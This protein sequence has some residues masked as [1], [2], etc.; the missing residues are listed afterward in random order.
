MTVYIMHISLRAQCVC[1]RERVCVCVHF[2]CCF[3]DARSGAS[4]SSAVCVVMESL[5]VNAS[6][7]VRA[8]RQGDEERSLKECLVARC[9]PCSAL[10]NNITWNKAVR[11]FAS[12]V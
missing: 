12:H 1:V 6:G 9:S 11:Y 4:T 8:D 5:G 7:A 3:T 2:T 10:V